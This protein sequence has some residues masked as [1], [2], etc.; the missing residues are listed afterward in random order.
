MKRAVAITL[1]ALLVMACDREPEGTDA[2][3][4]PPTTPSA[5]SSLP[6][7]Q[8]DRLTIQLHLESKTVEAGGQIDS[9]V[10]VENR[11]D[12]PVRDPRCLIAAPNFGL[13]PESDPHAELWGQAVVDCSG[14]FTFRPGYIDRFAGPTFNATD[15]FGDPLPPGD[16]IATMRLERRTDPITAPVEVTP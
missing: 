6:G 16:Y 9:Q 11:S 2:V 1:F 14:P 13:V 4:R 12:R 7:G 3:G 8:F 5:P 15:K 10:D